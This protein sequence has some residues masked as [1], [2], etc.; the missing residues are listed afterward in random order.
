MQGNGPDGPVGPV[1]LIEKAEML[2]FQLVV[3]SSKLVG[4]FNPSQKY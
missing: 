3:T 2:F 1:P 4:G